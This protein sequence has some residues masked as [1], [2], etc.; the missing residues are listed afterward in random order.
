MCPIHYILLLLILFF[1]GLFGKFIKLIQKGFWSRWTEF[2]LREFNGFGSIHWPVDPHCSIF[3]KQ[4]VVWF[5]NL[6]ISQGYIRHL[7][8]SLA[9]P[10][11][12]HL[13]RYDYRRNVSTA[14]SFVVGKENEKKKKKKKAHYNYKKKRKQKQNELSSL[15]TIGNRKP[16]SFEMMMISSKSTS[17][18]HFQVL[19]PI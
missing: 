9:L 12:I 17:H 13:D 1:F 6:Q 15:K 7:I 3:Q 2:W 16:P 4:T 8:Q 18:N 5:G 14:F 19:K 11:W 10:F